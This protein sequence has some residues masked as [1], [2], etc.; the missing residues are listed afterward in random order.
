MWKRSAGFD[1][2][3][4]VG[5][6]T[7]DYSGMSQ[8]ISH[9]LNSVPEMIWVKRRD[10]S[11]YWG[12]YHKGL[13]GGT[14]PENYRMLL[15]DTHAESAASGSYTNWYWNNTAPTATHFSVG[16]VPNANAQNSQIIGILFASVSG[17]SHVGSYSG[18]GS[19]G[20]AQNIGFQP[21]YLLIKRRNSTSDWMQFN[22]LGGFDKYTQLNT[23]QQ[24]YSQ[25]YVN[26]SAT[27]FS[28]VSDYGDTNE[29]GSTYIYYAHA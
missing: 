6:S 8:V 5:N 14:N 3:T 9:N 17:I 10:A 22:S 16:E 24:Q 11:G 12:V 23:N 25:T 13:N 4:Y 1:V 7:G 27:G 2:V 21:R 26:V 19:T 28:L 18:S 20:N 29:S 15:N